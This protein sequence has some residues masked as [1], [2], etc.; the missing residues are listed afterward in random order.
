MLFIVRSRSRTKT[1]LPEE[2]EGKNSRNDKRNTGSAFKQSNKFHTMFT[3]SH[4]H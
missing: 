3:N 2:H 4:T 1:N